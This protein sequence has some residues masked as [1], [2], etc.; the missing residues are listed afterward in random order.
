M[1]CSTVKYLLIARYSKRKILLK[2]YQFKKTKRLQQ[3]FFPKCIQSLNR[4]RSLVSPFPLNFFLL[5][6][7]SFLNIDR[8]S[9]WWCWITV[10]MNSLSKK[11]C[12]CISLL[13]D[14]KSLHIWYY[15]LIFAI[16]FITTWSDFDHSH[17]RHLYYYCCC[18]SSFVVDYF[19]LFR[20]FSYV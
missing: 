19:L 3:N 7:L 1:T 16:N 9:G 10:D 8:N 6:S 13:Y 17:H 18:S 15:I 5:N 12:Y 20:F 4:H 14:Q 2:W 11:K